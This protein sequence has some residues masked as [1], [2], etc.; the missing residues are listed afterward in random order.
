MTS[1]WLLANHLPR[2]S[3]VAFARDGE[4]N[5]I[6]FVSNWNSKSIHCFTK[7]KVPSAIYYGA[8]NEP[9]SWGYDV[10]T[11]V[12]AIR[13][14]KLLLL[15]DDHMPAHVKDSEYITRAKALLQRENKHA[16]EVVAD[17]LRE[18]WK[19]SLR[20]I[21]KA[22]GERM[23][24]LSIFKLVVTVPAI[25][26]PHAQMRMHEAIV[27]AGMLHKRSAGETSLSFLPEPE[28]AALA[29]L[30]K[31]SARPDMKVCWWRFD[32]R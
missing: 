28:A 17:C 20:A 2:Y 11:E 31:M 12:N 14:F 1:Q 25:W 10:T 5:R 16:T 7:Q 26:P 30:D 4:P 8:C 9:P 23:V 15:D 19:H 21:E 22:I 29:T 6:H 13:W 32:T 18:L 3:G 24:S 27:M